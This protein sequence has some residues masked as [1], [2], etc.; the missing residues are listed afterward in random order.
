MKN[1]KNQLPQ[2]TYDFLP[3]ECDKKTALEMKLRQQFVA[4]GYREIQTPAFEYYDVFL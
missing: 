3:D 2:G 4:Q 1:L